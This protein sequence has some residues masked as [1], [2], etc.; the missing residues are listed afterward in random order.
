MKG[1]ERR[2]QLSKDGHLKLTTGVVGSRNSPSFTSSW[3]ACGERETE[4]KGEGRGEIRI[5]GPHEYDVRPEEEGWANLCR[6]VGEGHGNSSTL[7]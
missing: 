5:R 2:E 1:K 7:F 6:V 4:G 3:I